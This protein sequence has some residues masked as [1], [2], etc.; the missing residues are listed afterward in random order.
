MAVTRNGWSTAAGWLPSVRSTL[1]KESS[2]ILRVAVALLWTVLLLSTAQSDTSAH[3]VQ[4]KLP[5]LR[6]NYNVGVAGWNTTLD[7]ANVAYSND[8][9][10]LQLMHA[11]LV[12]ILPPSK[13]NGPSKVALNLA[14][15]LTISKNRKVY[16]FHIR[17][18]ARF[19]N[20][21][22]VHT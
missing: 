22:K 6:L 10:A 12:Q 3:R 17:K 1:V 20:G 21:D 11:G 8:A 9:D 7:P 19:S 18:R 15:K 4:T 13:L 2:T 14:D 16:T 5:I